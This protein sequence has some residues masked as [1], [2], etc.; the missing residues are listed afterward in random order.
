MK[1]PEVVAALLKHEHEAD[2]GSDAKKQPS[3]LRPKGAHRQVDTRQEEGDNYEGKK[4]PAVHPDCDGQKL[5]KEETAH[6]GL[7]GERT[8]PR[9]SEIHRSHRAQNQSNYENALWNPLTHA[10]LPFASTIPRR[11]AQSYCDKPVSAM[12]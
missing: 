1:Q 5:Q 6:V 7:A 10:Y 4:D 2:R 12:L 3:C 9:K 8:R 11:L